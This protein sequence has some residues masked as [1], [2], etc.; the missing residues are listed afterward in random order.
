M[1]NLLN[2]TDRRRLGVRLRAVRPD[3]TGRWG[4]M[5]AHQ[6]VCH[7]ADALRVPLGDKLA[8]PMPQ[9]LPIPLMKFVALRVPLPW[10]RGFP[11]P[12]ELRQ[13]VGGTRPADFE[14]DVDD[15]V[16]LLGRFASAGDLLAL[17]RHPIFG[18]LTVHEWGR[19]G[20]LHTNHH[21]RQF[22]C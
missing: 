12:P 14:R 19:W 6:M 7:L 13:G 5:S 10:P 22:G 18:P 15:L 1:R 20:Y 17:S 16:A 2:E 11:A 21:L 8:R 9:M 3:S 4:R